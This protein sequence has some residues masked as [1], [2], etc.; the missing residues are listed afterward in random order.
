MAGA[1]AM[2]RRWVLRTCHTP[3]YC[4]LSEMLRNGLLRLSSML[5]FQPPLQWQADSKIESASPPKPGAGY[6]SATGSTGFGGDE[7]KTQR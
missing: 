5:L 3:L 7:K 4:F 6:S 1:T 2:V